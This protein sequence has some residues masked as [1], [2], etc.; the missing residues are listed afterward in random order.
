M[1]VNTFFRIFFASVAPYASQGHAG[2]ER[3]RRVVLVVF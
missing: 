3:A 2:V 1:F